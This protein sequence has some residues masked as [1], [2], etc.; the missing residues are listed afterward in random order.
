MLAGLSHVT[1]VKVYDLGIHD[2]SLPFYSIDLLT[3][4]TLERILADDGA[5][6]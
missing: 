5:L 4:R 2:R 3:G 6:L 1:L